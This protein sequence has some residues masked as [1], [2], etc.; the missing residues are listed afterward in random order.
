MNMI[1]W[2]KRDLKEGE[3]ITIYQML[4]GKLESNEISFV[5]GI[6]LEDLLLGLSQQK[7]IDEETRY[8]Q[9][10]IAI[11]MSEARRSMGRGKR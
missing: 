10:A 1:G 2:A 8:K 7:E 11:A 5:E 3:Y 6:T 4:D 9:Q